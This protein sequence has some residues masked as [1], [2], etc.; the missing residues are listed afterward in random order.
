MKRILFIVMMC[1]SIVACKKHEIEDVETTPMVTISFD[2]QIVTSNSMVRSTSNEFLDIIE[3]QTPDYVNVTLVNTD[4]N[5]TY[6]C[7]SNETITI[8]IGNYEISAEMG[9]NS[10][11]YVIGTSGSMYSTPILSMNKTNYT[12]THNTNLITLNVYYKCYAVFALID[13]C[14]NCVAYYIDNNVD[15][16]K[17]GK[18]YVAYFKYTESRGMNIRL[19]PYDDS[20]E[21]ITTT[22]NFSTTYD[23]NRVF[24]EF[25]KYYVIHP[26]KVDKT[27]CSFNV[28]ITDMQEGEI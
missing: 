24:A 9:A 3:E 11:K 6:T 1:V 19:T 8:P 27:S 23:V 13:E 28:N 17:K 12:I 2:Q 18:Y 5:K 14:K 16:Y 4:L 21:F 10:S 25:G 22:Y 26:Q 20:T 15:F 7:K